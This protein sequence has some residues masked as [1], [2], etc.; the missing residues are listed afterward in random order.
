MRKGDGLSRKEVSRTVKYA[1]I[2][3]DEGNFR[4]TMRANIARKQETNLVGLQVAIQAP[5]T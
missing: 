3:G 2:C 4:S 5:T 1:F